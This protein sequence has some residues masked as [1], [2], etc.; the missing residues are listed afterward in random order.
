[1]IGRGLLNG[2]SRHDEARAAFADAPARLDDDRL[3]MPEHIRDRHRQDA[4]GGL[5]SALLQAGDVGGAEKA[6]RAALV[7]AA[8]LD[9]AAAHTDSHR[10]LALVPVARRRW[11]ETR[12]SSSRRARR[13]SRLGPRPRG[14]DRRRTRRA[15]AAPGRGRRCRGASP[16]MTEASPQ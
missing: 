13:S 9:V 15:R 7:V 6:R 1:M 2:L 11:D 12:A 5:G 8:R 16:A 14:G 4:R 10:H 3:V